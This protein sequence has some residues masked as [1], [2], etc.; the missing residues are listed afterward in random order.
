MEAVQ[1]SDRNPIVA[2]DGAASAT[3][4]RDSVPDVTQTEVAAGARRLHVLLADDDVACTRH[5]PYRNR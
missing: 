3:R 4:S 2:A 1:A 5:D